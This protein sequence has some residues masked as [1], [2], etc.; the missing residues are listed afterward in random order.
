VYVLLQ[1]AGS[2]TFRKNIERIA[3]GKERH[4]RIGHTFLAE[5][6]EEQLSA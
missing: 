6:V 1:A 4:I 3:V 2:L 5:D